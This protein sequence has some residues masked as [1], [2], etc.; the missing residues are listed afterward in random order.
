MKKTKD[1][2][3]IFSNLSKAWAY[4]KLCQR[5]GLTPPEIDLWLN[6]YNNCAKSIG[7]KI[8]GYFKT[9]ENAH[10]AKK[11]LK[12]QKAKMSDMPIVEIKVKPKLL[13]RTTILTNIQ[14][15]DI[16]RNISIY[17]MII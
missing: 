11:C 1:L 8:E 9:I 15:S 14:L 6:V 13:E 3:K 10:N 2:Y 5:T 16:K 7:N 17:L 4:T 12:L